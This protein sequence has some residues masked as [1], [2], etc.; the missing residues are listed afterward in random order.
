MKAFTVI[1]DPAL[2]PIMGRYFELVRE[3]LAA[4]DRA[5]AAGDAE[6]VRMVG[7]RLKGNGTSYGFPR[8]TELG[9]A[10]EQ[11]AMQGDLPGADASAAEVREFIDAV[12]VVYGKENAG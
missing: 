8:L 5:M 2:E 1:V 4:A 6:G 7:H 9:A 11:A 12:R 3:D 10:M